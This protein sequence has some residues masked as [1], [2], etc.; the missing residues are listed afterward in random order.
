MIRAAHLEFPYR[1]SLSRSWGPQ[2]CGCAGPLF[3]GVNPSDANANA[4][5]PFQWRGYA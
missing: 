1:Y 5:V 2:L 4:T 3:I